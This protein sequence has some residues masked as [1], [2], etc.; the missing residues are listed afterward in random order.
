MFTFRYNY[1]GYRDLDGTVSL[2]I[3][4]AR[5]AHSSPWASTVS[6]S[7]SPP[8]MTG[9][10]DGPGRLSQKEEGEGDEE[11]GEQEEEEPKSPASLLQRL[12]IK[13]ILPPYGVAGRGERNKKGTPKDQSPI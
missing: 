7:S 13:D 9:Q 10:E 3:L 5:E 12:M 4:T 6:S 11:P 8:G 2:S 1:G